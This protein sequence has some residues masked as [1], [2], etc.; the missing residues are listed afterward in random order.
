[1]IINAIP[2]TNE[3]NRAPKTP[4]PSARRKAMKERPQAMGCRIMTRVRA[5]VVSVEAV[6]NVVPSI[7]EMMLAGL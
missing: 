1:M 5:L 7:W 4:A 3:A 2:D 6:L